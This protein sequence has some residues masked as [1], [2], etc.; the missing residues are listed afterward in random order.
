MPTSPLF[1]YSSSKST[2]GLHCFSNTWASAHLRALSKHWFLT[3][4]H[5]LLFLTLLRSVQ[6]PTPCPNHSINCW[7][8]L[9]D[10]HYF[11]QLSC[12]YIYLL[13]YFCLPQNC[14][15]YG[16]KDLIRLVYYSILGHLS[17]S[18]V[19][20]HPIDIEC[21]VHGRQKPSSQVEQLMLVPFTHQSSLQDQADTR[22][23]LQPYFCYASS[24]FLSFSL[25]PFLPQ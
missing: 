20:R 3:S 10:N 2:T 4:F 17:S 22:I 8:S 19:V 21:L 18:P 23:Y 15:L 16:S 5:S 1:F 12:C 14:G 25:I 24:Y 6:V 13:D 11:Q 9:L 7:F